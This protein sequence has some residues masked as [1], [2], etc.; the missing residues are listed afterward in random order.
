MAEVDVVRRAA[1][2][3]Y[4]REGEARAVVDAWRASGEPLAAFCREHGVARVRVARWAAR[5]EPGL[6]VRFHPVQLRG[7]VEPGSRREFAVELPD[8]TTI[9]VPAGFEVADLRRIL[10]AV[11]P[12]PGC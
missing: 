11:A 12:H 9:R 3:R 2:S 8:G 1:R 6:A 7:G 5:L 10:A 4:W